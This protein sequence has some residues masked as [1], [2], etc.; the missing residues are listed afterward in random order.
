VGKVEE[1]AVPVPSETKKLSKPLMRDEAYAD[2][3]RW[4]VD[5]IL[6]PGERLRDGELA[7][8]LGVSRM[9]V[10]EAIRRLEDEGLVETAANRWTRVSFVDVE[11]AKRIYPILAALES[12]AISL[13]APRMGKEDLRRMTEANERLRKALESGRGIAASEADYEFHRVFIARS[14]NPDLVGML[15]NLKTKLRRLEAAYFGGCMIANHS[16]VEHRDVLEALEDDD[17][18]CA[19]RAVE[20]NWQESLNRFLEQLEEGSVPRV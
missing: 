4:I 17:H 10:R 5:G 16:V 19:A 8:A 11:Q 3:R 9:P 15:E 12:L 20:T 18:R 14:D 6:K 2:L 7:E 1:V 13:A